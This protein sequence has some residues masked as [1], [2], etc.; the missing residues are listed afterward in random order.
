[1][2]SDTTT[3][4]MVL[5]ATR[6]NAEPDLL[7]H[8]GEINCLAI[9]R[10]ETIA[11]QGARSYSALMCIMITSQGLDEM[12]YKDYKQTAF[13]FA[14]I[15]GQEHHDYGEMAK[16]N[17]QCYNLPLTV[18]K[19]LI[20]DVYFS[21]VLRETILL[22]FNPEFHDKGFR[23]CVQAVVKDACEAFHGK[24]KVS[25]APAI[26][27]VTVT[28][29]RKQTPR[30][31][32]MPLIDELTSEHL[33][34]AY[35][36]TLRRYIAC[37]LYTK[38]GD[39]SVDGET[40]QVCSY[41]LFQEVKELLKGSKNTSCMT[42]PQYWQVYGEFAARNMNHAISSLQDKQYVEL[43]DTIIYDQSKVRNGDAPIVELT[44]KPAHPAL[45]RPADGNQVTGIPR[46]IMS[47]DTYGDSSLWRYWSPDADMQADY[48][49]ENI[50]TP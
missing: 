32:L 30:L 50:S 13:G 23:R 47:S 2:D 33:R 8:M 29:G 17:N 31:M 39:T 28:H 3:A 35:S 19:Q 14:V 22:V 48:H 27:T 12:F 1:M 43:L 24:D 44:I 15:K 5:E 34:F 49:Q 45:I 41:I 7:D 37:G 9:Q 10:L 40:G 42:L 36:R 38:S 16:H 4:R 11:R 26:A 18:V 21:T 20:Y 6:L 25:S 46:E